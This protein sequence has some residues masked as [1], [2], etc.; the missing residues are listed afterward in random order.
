VDE[1]KPGD[2]KKV[3]FDIVHVR[4]FNTII[5]YNPSC[6]QGPALSLGWKRIKDSIYFLDEYDVKHR[7]SNDELIL[8]SETRESILSK[9]GYTKGDIAASVR[10]II[11]VRNQRRR[12]SQTVR[13]QNLEFAM[14]RVGKRFKHLLQGAGGINR[15]VEV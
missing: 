10:K 14:E 15:K 8:S 6:S 1:Y 5:D 7:R 13:A 4:E 3:C 12:T 2:T 9:L 11:K